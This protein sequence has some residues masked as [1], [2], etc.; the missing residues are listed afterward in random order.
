MI[1]GVHAVIFTTDAEA[2]SE[3][4]S[5]SGRSMLEAGG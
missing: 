4:C 2:D 3:T 5:S 1:T